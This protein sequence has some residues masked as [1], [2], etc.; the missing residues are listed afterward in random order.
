MKHDKPVEG[1]SKDGTQTMNAPFG[2]KT[3][4]DFKVGFVE[5][6]IPSVSNIWNHWTGNGNSG[7]DAVAQVNGIDKTQMSKGH[8]K[9]QKR[10]TWKTE[11]LT[12][13]IHGM[14]EGAQLNVKGI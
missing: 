1:N 6:I 8:R 10:R 11:P 9:Q 2:K 4:F 7:M 5:K 13:L 3:D 14:A 12:N